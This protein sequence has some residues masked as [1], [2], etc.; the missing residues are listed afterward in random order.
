MNTNADSMENMK[1]GESSAKKRDVDSDEENKGSESLSEVREK[2]VKREKTPEYPYP[3]STSGFGKT[4][5]FRISQFIS[6]VGN[7]EDGYV[8]TTRRR[9]TSK[10]SA[11]ILFHYISDLARLENILGNRNLKFD[12]MSMPSGTLLCFGNT[13]SGDIKLALRA[14]APRESCEFEGFKLSFAER[15]Q[16]LLAMCEIHRMKDNRVEKP[17]ARAPKELSFVLSSLTS[18]LPRMN[19]DEA[20]VEVSKDMTE[21]EIE[22]WNDTQR[23]HWNNQLHAMQEELIEANRR[24]NNGWDKPCLDTALTNPSKAARF[25]WMEKDH[26]VNDVDKETFWSS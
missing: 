18:H 15:V 21:A 3:T 6:L 7:Y 10:P 9:G 14:E 4:R 2:R 22:Q 20:F 26:L 19:N 11:T 23:P 16:F 8:M 5:W 12:C 1:S 24:C 25:T 13:E 17:G